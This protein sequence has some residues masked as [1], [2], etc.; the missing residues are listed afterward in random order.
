MDDILSAENLVLVFSDIVNSTSLRESS[1][2][3][4]SEAKSRHDSLIRS[5]LVEWGG[6]EI[7]TTGDGFFL[8]F[9][10]EL[11]S[12][13]W[14]KAVQTLIAQQM[15]SPDAPIRIR[16]GLHW[17]SANPIFHPDGRRDY[18]AASVNFAQRIMGEAEGGEILVSEAFYNQ[19]RGLLSYPFELRERGMRNLRGIGERRV[20]QLVHPDLP[21]IISHPSLTCEIP[22]HNIKHAPHAHFYGREQALGELRSKLIRSNGHPVVLVGMGGIGKTQM[23]AEYAHAHLT[24]ECYPEGIFW[25]DARNNE[26]LLADYTTIGQTFFGLDDRQGRDR[27]AERV[28]RELQQLRRPALI[29]FDNVTEETDLELLPLSRNLHLLF[30]TQRQILPASYAI[31]ELQP[32]SDE[33]A[34][35]LLQ[36]YRTAPNAAERAAAE[37]IAHSVGKLPLALALAAHDMHVRGR[38]FAR[39]WQSLSANPYATLQRAREHFI[40][41]TGHIGSV[42]DTIDLAVRGNNASGETGRQLNPNALK[43]LAAAACF[44][45]NGIPQ[46][47]LRKASGIRC[48]NDFDDAMIALWNRSLLERDEDERQSIH[49]LIRIYAQ[50]NLLPSRRSS[51]LPRV[52]SALSAHLCQA[53]Q[54]GELALVRDDIA[55]CIAAVELAKSCCVLPAGLEELLWEMTLF[56]SNQRADTAALTYAVQGAALSKERE[57]EQSI[58]Y[59]KFLRLVGEAQ[60]ETGDSRNALKSVRCAWCIARQLLLKTDA[61]MA[62][63]CNSVGYILKKQ[64]RSKRALPF[65]LCALAIH[66]AQNETPEIAKVLNNIGTL[67]EAL[68]EMPTALKHL[69]RALKIQ[70]S[71]GENLYLVIYLNNTGRV[72]CKLGLYEEALHLHERARHIAEAEQGARHPDTGSCHYYIAEALRGLGRFDEALTHARLAKRIYEK[73]NADKQFDEQIQ[74]IRTQIALLA[75][76]EN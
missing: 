16:I 12:A 50:I 36:V 54:G 27:T 51:L 14:A 38:S 22:R 13:H 25:L 60:Q 56:L 61:K 5:T 52:L 3:A 73:A 15:W 33:D 24:T 9:R 53:N 20:W 4:F 58:A 29:I 47:V 31:I 19:V 67:Y 17:G 26:R 6:N 68:G 45:P 71:F 74:T 39:Y 23:A 10:S 40:S 44:A 28:C 46:E 62:D 42:Y 59:A 8:T 65:Y 55:H 2:T 48:E 1:P 37:S 30:T 41:A 21:P 34:L 70:T 57:G 32:L 18:E 75:P 63:Y 43:V 76:N 72:K 69:E 11:N 35:R 7:N 49:E 66:E 64:K